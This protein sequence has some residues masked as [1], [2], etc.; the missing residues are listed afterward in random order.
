VAG[1]EDGHIYRWDLNRLPQADRELIKQI[2]DRRVTAVAF[3]PNGLWMAAAFGPDPLGAIPFLNIWEMQNLGNATLPVNVHGEIITHLEFASSSKW[4]AGAAEGGNQ[5]HLWNMGTGATNPLPQ[6]LQVDGFND[7]TFSPN[8]RWVAVAQQ[9]KVEVW[10]LKKLFREGLELPGYRDLVLAVE[11]SHDSRSLA[12]GDADGQIHLWDT[13]DFSDGTVDETQARIYN[14]FDITVNSLA[15]SLDGSQLAA[16]GDE[17]VRLW[18]FPETLSAPVRIDSPLRHSSLQNALLVQP[19]NDRLFAMDLKGQDPAIVVQTEQP[20]DLVYFSSLDERYLAVIGNRQIEIWDL[21]N[22]VAPIFQPGPQ[23]GK[24]IAPTF[25]ADNRWF[26]YAVYDKIYALELRQPTSVVQLEGN[27]N[28]SPLYEFYTVDHWLFSRSSSE[29]LAWDTASSPLTVQTKV[30][31][32]SGVPVVHPPADDSAWIFTQQSRI[33]SAWNTTEP[34]DGPIHLEG[35]FWET[36]DNR[37]LITISEGNRRQLRELSSPSSVLAEF[38]NYRVSPSRRWLFY[39][40]TEGVLQLLDLYSP[41]PQAIP[42]ESSP[43][44]DPSFSPTDE[45]LVIPFKEGD[46]LAL[47]DLTHDMQMS[48]LSGTAVSLFSS[49]GHWLVTTSTKDSSFFLY[50]LTNSLSQ[51]E[52]PAGHIPA[53][54][55]PDNHWLILNAESG[56]TALFD[57]QTGELFSKTFPS[58]KGLEASP[59]GK[60]LHG[61]LSANS[62]TDALLIDLDDPANNLPILRGHTDEL[63]GMD[64]TADGRF[65]LTYGNDRTIRI[66]DLENLATDPVVLRHEEP[67][68]QVKFSENGKWLLAETPHGIYIWPWKIEDAR[69]LACRLVGRNLTQ[70]EWAKYV[71]DTDREP[72]CTDWP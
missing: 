51:I 1:L 12:T 45:W 16:A 14:S 32:S 15:F 2:P 42:V 60:W 66:W 27:R 7:I 5:L 52:L 24:V 30:S 64:F 37:W 33:L 56:E 58:N 49:D 72:T 41:V 9:A 54:F 10:D 6:V 71:G 43:G 65:L 48:E 61:I 28:G 70:D 59:D 29:V 50:D 68:Q 35:I 47:Y 19:S 17:Q 36:I 69:E 26:I 40:D 3:S 21:Q 53:S 46:A 4:L 44:S 23:G 63:I 67:V 20:G 57:L 13:A 62:G 55:S 31:T 39:R 25:T 8:E 34:A 38:N 11:F 22:P 18:N